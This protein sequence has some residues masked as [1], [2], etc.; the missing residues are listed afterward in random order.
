MHIPVIFHNLSG[1][2]GHIIMQGIG[3]MECEDDIDPIPYNMEKY[4]AFKLGFL[5]FIDSLQFIKSSLDK[6]ASNLGAEKCRAQEC[7]N[8]Q[9]LWR[10]DAGRCFAHPENFKITR[11]QIPPELLEIYLK[12]GV[13]PYEYMDDWKKF[14]KTSL[15][16]KEAF[17]SKL[18]ETHISDKEYEYAL[19]VWEK[20]GCKTMQDYH[21]IYLKTDVLLLADI[22][23]NFREMAL[24]KYGLD[25]LCKRYAR[26]N[27]P[28]ME[29]A[30]LQYLPTGNFHWVKEKNKLSNI[31]RQIE[32]NEIPDDSSEGYIL[33]VK[34]EWLSKKQQEIIARSGQ[35]YTPTD[36]LIPNLFDKDEYVV[37]YRNLQY[38]VSQGLVIK[39]VYEAI[40][41]EQAPWMKPYIE[42]NTAERAKAKN[43]FEKDFYKLM[44]N[45]VFGKTME[46][47][48]KRV[49]VSVVQ[50]QTHPKKYKKLTSDPAFKG[51]KIFSEN[52][53]AIYRQKVEKQG[54]V[55]K[56][57][58]E[59]IKFEQAPWMKPYIEFNTAKRAKAKNN[60]EKDFYKFINNSVF[61]KT[62][63]NLRKR[64]YYTD[65]DSLLVQIQTEDINADFID[66]A[67]QFD[68]SDYSKD[69]SVRKALGDKA[70]INMK[71][72]G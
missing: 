13:Y 66:M 6:L 36:K 9:H 31:Q 58:Y 38:Y 10:I 69:Y 2:D 15:P 27:N 59:A 63:E 29:K 5:R 14:E 33:K 53:V 8:P 21:D 17:Y 44:N 49:R 24:K 19:Y 23:Q 41:F 30:M 18:N 43:D 68:F 20:A 51:R 52:L 61:G 45:S 56:K 37:H 1:Y 40:K 62:M 32:S 65:T 3:A 25:P 7:S 67:D 22:F 64:L 48:R 11:S 55:I 46:N 12:K 54:L 35:R 26:A 70:D 47:L 16:P 60:F 50:P 57:I 72:P 39:K 34:K 28:D 71:I 4:M 42:F